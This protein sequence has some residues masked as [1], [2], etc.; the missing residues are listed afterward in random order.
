RLQGSGAILN[1]RA[2]VVSLGRG[3]GPDDEEVLIGGQTLMAGPG[4]QDHDV[5]GLEREDPALV[6]AEARATLAAR[7]AE[8][9]MNPG[10]V[11]DVVVDAVAPGIA[12]TV[13]LEQFFHP[14]RRIV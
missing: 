1:L 14:A 2:F 3:I 11:M 12:T 13:G 6:A 9:L 10:M 8:H 5:T 7:D 4:R